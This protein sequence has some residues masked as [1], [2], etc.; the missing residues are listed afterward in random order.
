MT[1]ADGGYDDIIAPAQQQQSHGVWCTSYSDSCTMEPDSI[2]VQHQVSCKSVMVSGALMVKDARLVLPACN[3]T[4][5]AVVHPHMVSTRSSLHAILQLL[6]I[7]CP[8][9]PAR[10]H[11]EKEKAFAYEGNVNMLA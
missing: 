1:S 3:L 2:M 7:H 5:A 10:S 6:G 11:A 9:R 4:S 8:G